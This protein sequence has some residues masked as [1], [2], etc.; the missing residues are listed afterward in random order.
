MTPAVALPLPAPS[1]GLSLIFYLSKGRQR[2]KDTGLMGAPGEGG[3]VI[4]ILMA[5]NGH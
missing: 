5:I 3:G 1:A 2:R 4:F